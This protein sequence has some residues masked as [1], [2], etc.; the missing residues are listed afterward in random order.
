MSGPSDVFIVVDFEAAYCSL[1]SENRS[2]HSTE[3]GVLGSVSGL[4]PVLLLYGHDMTDHH[5]TDF[6][7]GDIEDPECSAEVV[8][9]CGTW[10][11]SD[12]AP[13]YAG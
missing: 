12:G 3:S 6:C 7:T 11:S 10:A 4:T 8:Y 9:E 13:N 1:S 5:W 2:D